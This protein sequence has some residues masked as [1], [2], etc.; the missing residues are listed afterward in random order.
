MIFRDGARRGREAIESTGARAMLS[1]IQTGTSML[2][3]AA[4]YVSEL[5]PLRRVRHAALEQLI[6]EQ[7]R[8]AHAGTEA[9]D[10]TV[11]ETGDPKLRESCASSSSVSS[12]RRSSR[13]RR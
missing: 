12:C 7:L 10:R 5:V 13:R 2:S 4:G 9:Y 3:A 8:W 11:P 6:V 1:V